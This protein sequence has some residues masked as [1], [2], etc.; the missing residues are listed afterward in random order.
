[1]NKTFTRTALMAVF[2]LLLFTGGCACKKVEQGY[3]GIKAHLYG[4][5]KG[6]VEEVGP[7]RHWYNP[8]R[9][10]VYEFPNFIQ[11]IAWT[12]IP[13]D[14]SPIDEAIRV[15]SKDQLEFIVDI[16][17]MYRVSD[18]PGCSA[19]IFR[20]YRKPIESIT[21]GPI[22]DIIRKEVQD[23]FSQF[24][25]SDIYGDKRP[26]VVNKIDSLITR[27]LAQIK[28]DDGTACFETRDFA[29]LKLLP[30]QTVIAAVE[31]KIKASQDAEKELEV[32]RAVRYRAQQ[33]SVKAVQEARNNQM[34]RQSIT[35]ELIE[36]EKVRKWD[37][38]L[39]QVAGSGGTIIDLK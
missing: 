17:F 16:G 38:K 36:W 15:M 19:T 5:E 33:D 20:L 13:E 9:T 22:R 25:A 34:I 26:V 11:R 39:P 27:R 12:Q 18:S 30:P 4:G 8:V 35:P 37:G 10:E 21:N 14:A 2:A 23:V 6:G 28:N 32:L 3:T 31:Q 29:L 1:M 7:G 24:N